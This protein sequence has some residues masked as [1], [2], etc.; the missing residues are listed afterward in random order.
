MTQPPTQPPTQRPT[1]PPTQGPDPDRATPPEAR[2]TG[3][4]VLLT[5]LLADRLGE[6]PSTG[7]AVAVDEQVVPRTDWA[8]HVVRPGDVVEVVRAVA[9]G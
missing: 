9:G 1:Q 2:Y 6:V 7:V 8:T 3:P 5:D 4:A